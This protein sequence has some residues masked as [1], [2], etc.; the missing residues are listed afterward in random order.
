MIQEN[1]DIDIVKIF[2]YLDTKYR[3]RY[4]GFANLIELEEL[5]KLKW[6]QRIFR[7][8]GQ[9]YIWERIYF[10]HSKPIEVCL[11]IF[12]LGQEITKK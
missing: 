8:D 9:E 12:K 4:Y 6:W 11:E 1:K 3:I 7:T 10:G 5:V 2:D